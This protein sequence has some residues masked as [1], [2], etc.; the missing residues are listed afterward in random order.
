MRSVRLSEHLKIRGLSARRPSCAPRPSWRPVRRRPVRRSRRSARTRLRDALARRNSRIRSRYQATVACAAARASAAST[1]R[2]R[3]ATTTLV[4]RR[5]TSHSQGPG[6]VSSKSLMP[7]TRLRSA[8]PKTPKFDTCM[9]P[10][11]CTATPVAGVAARSAAIT[12]AAPRK[13]ENGDPSMR[14][15]RTGTNSANP[16]HI[17][18]LDDLDRVCSLRRRSILRMPGVRQPF[19]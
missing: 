17:L 13:N 12:P 19:S 3:V 16:R 4:A 2:K 8:E 7:K 11:A 5:L 15:C 14:A 1:P 9:S 10:Q 6:I 18:R